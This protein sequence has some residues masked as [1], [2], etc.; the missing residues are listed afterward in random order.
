MYAKSHSYGEFVF[1]WGWAEAYERAGLKYYP[2]LV[3]AAP[4]TP[5]TGAR[6]LCAERQPGDAYEPADLLVQA[7]R[8]VAEQA[9]V[10]SLHWLFTR[11][12]ESE[13][14]GRLG[15][16][17]RTGVQYHWSNPGYRDFQDFLDALTS[18]RRKQIRKERREAGQAPVE[19]LVL[20]GSEIEDAQWDAYHA[21]YASTYDR[22]WGFPSLTPGFFKQVGREM[23]EGVMLLLARRDG[24]YV[25]GAHLFKGDDALYGR[26]W[27]CSEFHQAL[28][29]EMCYYRC[30][31]FCI[32][33]GLKRFEAGA[34]GEHK[35]M[36]GFLPVRTHSAHWL[37]HDAF[38]DAVGDFL[39]RE[40]IENDRHFEY[41]N[42]HSPFR[43]TDAGTGTDQ[44]GRE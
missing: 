11:P 16:L 33:R 9:Q 27:G 7:V 19:I 30:I 36:R 39:R 14:L 15:H 20:E 43:C 12:H 41:M 22:K 17:R 35:I 2:K 40:R 29:F 42:T 1:D 25:A 44:G 28:H 32:E 3:V 4:Y 26:N 34:Q 37:R 31:E 13:R 10:S 5:A 18:K 8:Q 24:R 23:P 21:L 38:K 6:L